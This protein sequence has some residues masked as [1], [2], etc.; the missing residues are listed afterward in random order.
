MPLPP[1][2][3]TAFLCVYA[4]FNLGELRGNLR[5]A[6]AARQQRGASVQKLP[7]GSGG[8]KASSSAAASGSSSKATP[9]KQKTPGSGRKQRKA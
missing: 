1:G 3:L 6:Q 9:A 7:P 4:G 2:V 5:A 8:A